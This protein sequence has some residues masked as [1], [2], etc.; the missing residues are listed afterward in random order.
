MKRITIARP[1]AVATALERE[2]RHRGAP[3]SQLAREV[4]ETSLS[5]V[6]SR[7][8]SPPFVAL[9]RSGHRTTARDIDAIL[10][11]EWEPD[12]PSDGD[13]SEDARDRAAEVKLRAEALGDFLD[14][15]EREHG[16]LTA[17]ELERAERELGLRDPRG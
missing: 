5:R 13:G 9:G 4:I 16:A 10:E 12:A 7:R 15:W 8:R 3:V 2:A 1:N 11:A 17:Q 14:E 6:A